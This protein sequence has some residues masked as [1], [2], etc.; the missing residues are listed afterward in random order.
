LQH[1]GCP[2]N[3]SK[4]VLFSF[5]Q[6]HDFDECRF[7]VSVNDCVWYLRAETPEEKQ[8]WVD[9]LDAYKVKTIVFIE[10]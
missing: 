9:I 10:T 4:N 1:R 5:L 7:D 8:H 6:P 2:N 3:I